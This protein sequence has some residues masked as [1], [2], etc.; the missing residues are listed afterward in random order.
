MIFPH[1]IALEYLF[2]VFYRSHKR[3]NGR[4][5]RK[6]KKKRQADIDFELEAKQYVVEQSKAWHLCVPVSVDNLTI[7]SL[8]DM[9]KHNKTKYE[10]PGGVLDILYQADV[11]RF[12]EIACMSMWNTNDMV[13]VANK[14]FTIAKVFTKQMIEDYITWFYNWWGLTYLEQ[15]LFIN[16]VIDKSLDESVEEK[17][18]SSEIKKYYQLHVDRF[19]S[20][21][22]EF[23]IFAALGYTSERANLSDMLLRNAIMMD[24]LQKRSI[25]DND[26]EQ[27]NIWSSTIKNN[28]EAMQ[29]L[30]DGGGSALGLSHYVKLM[31]MQAEETLS[32]EDIEAYNA[33][34]DQSD[35]ALPPSTQ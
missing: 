34:L 8:Q 6:G 29:K 11:R 26:A 3:L 2:A 13:T 16:L 12:I 35:A 10:F 17:R 22:G 25:L 32:K 28:V 18:T 4:Y 20:R 23:A 24:E 1:Q 5:L 30:A 33:K 15:H 9:K 19:F 14:N 31:T 27:A 7:P 21:R